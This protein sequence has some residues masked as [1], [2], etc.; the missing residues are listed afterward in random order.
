MD[1]PVQPG[2]TG[3]APMS[4]RPAPSSR[5]LGHHPLKVETRV[6]I[7]LGLPGVL[8]ADQVKR[9]GLPCRCRPLVTLEIRFVPLV[10]ALIWHGGP[11]TT[12]SPRHIGTRRSTRLRM[13]PPAPAIARR[14][15]EPL[16]V[17]RGES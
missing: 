14:R 12:S 13:A 5:G 9:F 6:R 10:M 11:S 8:A 7:P 16:P 4:A 1:R 17:R 3:T 15:C 2:A